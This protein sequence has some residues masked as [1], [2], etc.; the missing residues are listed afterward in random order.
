VAF[1]K[2]AKNCF[3][4]QNTSRLQKQINLSFYCSTFRRENT[5]PKPRLQLLKFSG[6]GG[7]FVSLGLLYKLKKKKMSIMKKRNETSSILHAVASSQGL[8][9]GHEHK[10]FLPLTSCYKTGLPLSCRQL[11]DMLCAFRHANA[12]GVLKCTDI[13]CISCL[14]QD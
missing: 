8:Q 3:N 13:L 6:R 9:R 7:I 2:E 11:M 10:Y 14:R 4:L 5:E 1:C 12:F